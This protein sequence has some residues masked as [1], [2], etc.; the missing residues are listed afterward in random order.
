MIARRVAGR[1]PSA[2]EDSEGEERS[3]GQE[4]GGVQQGGRPP[5][6]MQQHP[7]ERRRANGDAGA[8]GY[9]TGPRTFLSNPANAP[10]LTVQLSGAG[11]L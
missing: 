8:T 5:Q 10:S 11:I 4:E 2:T 6:P 9:V 7:A 1:L 3:A